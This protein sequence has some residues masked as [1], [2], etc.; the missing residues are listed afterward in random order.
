LKNKKL[1]NIKKN[2]KL[3]DLKESIES[4]NLFVTFDE[5]NIPKK[6]IRIENIVILN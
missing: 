4:D 5:S 3:Q 2:I 6:Y 1:I